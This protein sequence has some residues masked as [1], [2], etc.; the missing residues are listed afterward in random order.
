MSERKFTQPSSDQS[1]FAQVP[2]ADIERS[3]FDRS[4]AWK[5]TMEQAGQLIPIYWD[6]VLP[7][8]TFDLNTTVFARLATPLKPFMDNLKIQMHHFFC[9]NRLLMDD[10][11]QFMGDAR[12]GDPDD[13]NIPLANVIL[14]DNANYNTL[15]DALGL[16]IGQDFGQIGVQDLPFRAYDLIHY[17]WF[18]DQNVQPNQTGPDT[19]PG[20]TA[21]NAEPYKIRNKKRDYF[22]SCLPFAQ[23]GDPVLIPLGESAPVITDGTNIQWVIDGVTTTLG[24]DN[25]GDISGIK[26]RSSVGDATF[27]DAQFG[28]N[29][30]LLADLSSSIGT[31][32]NDLRTA[33]QIQR[34]LERDARGGTRYIEL[35]LSHFGVRSADSRMQR[36]EFLGAGSGYLNVNPIASTTTTQ[37]VP[38]A[39]LAAIGTGI[40]KG[41]FKHSFTEHG[42]VM[43]LLSIQSDLTYQQGIERQWSRLSRY[44]YYWPALAHLGEQPVLN[45]ELF[46]QNDFAEG[47]KTFGYQERYA[48]YRYKPSRITGTF[49]SNHPQS[50]DVWHLAQDFATPPSLNGEFI[51]ENPPIDRVIA[52]PSEP[53]FIID[54][55]HDLQCTRPMPVYSVPGLIDHF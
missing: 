48:E 40:A 27:D 5:G 34:L 39:N 41:G 45:Q 9:P 31:S 13:V 46:V 12:Q 24:Q 30:G 51:N 26:A 2:S 20:P 47:L 55:W 14:N 37:T 18:V 11:E 8:D 7:G 38:Q 29:T 6:E 15:P 4:H 42:I 35:V 3:K 44:D 28:A 49:R 10:W 17:E 53:H 21:R 16:P 50:L 1:H 23:K 19:G 32:I 25:Q 43:T 54:C 52:V 36:P 22:T 33:F